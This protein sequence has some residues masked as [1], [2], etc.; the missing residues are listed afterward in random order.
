M[1]PPM[2]QG[3][4]IVD[5]TSVIFGPLATRQLA[6]LGA[7]VIK[8]EP[9]GGDPFRYAG[10]PARTRGMGPC[11]HTLNRGKRSIVLDLK[12][13]DNARVMRDL[14]ATADLFIHNVRMK[15]MERLGFGY[16]AIRKIRPDIVYLHCAGFGSDGPY[17]GMPAYDDVIQA[18]SGATSLAGRVTGDARPLYVA[19]T[20]A[21]K[22]AGMAAA[23]AALAAL[24]HRERTGEG[25]FVEVPMFEAFTHFLFE[26]HLFG[27]TFDPPNAPVGYARQLDPN[28]Q[29]YPTADGHVAIV[30]YTDGKWVETFAVLDA[31]E[32]LAEERFSTPALRFANLSALNAEVARRTPARTTADWMARFGA[33]GIPIMPARDIADIRADPHLA[34]TG[35]FRPLDHP[36]EGPVVA[37][38]PPARFAA[39]TPPLAPAPGIDADG[40]ALRAELARG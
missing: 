26:E 25:Q 30:P 10:L 35:F 15:A 1:A 31:P 24:F 2:L 29:P 38:R 7:E 11:H 5:L 22:V 27:G 39:W 3:L 8:V 28:R 13:E 32:V 14:L 18:A 37:M 19:S 23:Q 33:A 20:I 40:A 21:D 17:A 6:D 34:A 9:P 16:D 36:S 12:Q 4:R